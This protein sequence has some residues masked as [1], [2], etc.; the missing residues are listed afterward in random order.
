M[1][2]LANLVNSIVSMGALAAV[3][4]LCE[5]SLVGRSLSGDNR[6]LTYHLHLGTRKVRL[7]HLHGHHNRRPPAHDLQ[8]NGEYGIV[9]KIL[10]QAALA[11]C[12]LSQVVLSTY[13]PLQGVVPTEA[14]ETTTRA[15]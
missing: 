14:M 8:R 5:R 6:Y 2:L 12:Y 13:N 4:H 10:G 11:F 15:K 3:G 9:D 7:R 1:Q